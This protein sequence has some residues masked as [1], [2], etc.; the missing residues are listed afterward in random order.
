MPCLPVVLPFYDRYYSFEIASLKKKKKQKRK[1][2][3]KKQKK[4][5]FFLRLPWPWYLITAT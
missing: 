2:K 3:R 4:K 5:P 1:K